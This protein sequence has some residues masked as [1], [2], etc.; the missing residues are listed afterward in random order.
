M[1]AVRS[2]EERLTA[3]DEEIAALEDE[4]PSRTT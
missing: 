4:R 2:L 1:D 3:L